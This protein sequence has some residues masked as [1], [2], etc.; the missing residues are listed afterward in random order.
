MDIALWS[1]WSRRLATVWLVVAAG[2]LTGCASTGEPGMFRSAGDKLDPIE[3]VNRVTYKFNDV[4]DKALIKPIAQGYKAVLPTQVRYCIGNV[5]GNISD[6]PTALN[7][8][9]QGKIKEG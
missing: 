8:F 7:N 4:L 1:R 3:P 6:V 9:L 2:V 5:F